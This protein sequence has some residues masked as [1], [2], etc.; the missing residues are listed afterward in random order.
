MDRLPGA[1]VLARALLS[2][3]RG[4]A[5][6]VLEVVAGVRLG[7]LAIRDGHTVAAAV[8]EPDEA[9]LGDLLVRAG[10]L[11]PERHREALDEGEPEGPVGAWLVREGLVTKEALNDGLFAQLRSRVRRIFEWEQAEFR[12]SAT[13]PD[14]G[15][16]ALDVPLPTQDLVLDA[17]RAQVAPIP[18]LLVRRRLGHGLYVLTSLGEEVVRGATLER[19]EAAMLPLLR[20]GA[21]VDSLLAIA[22]GHARAHRGLLALKLLGAASAPASGASFGLLLRKHREIARSASSR[23]LL[24]LEAKSDPGAARRA[25]RKLARDLHPDR[26]DADPSMQR[27]SSEVLKALVQAEADLRSR[28]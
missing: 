6:G 17:M 7:R 21:S 27:T 13:E 2:L 25:L 14:V 28:A 1:S 4:R 11:D 3:A 20:T 18:L 23:T 26:F 5:T 22:G 16:P 15:V 8:S 10:V 12:F 19:E 9:C 24:D